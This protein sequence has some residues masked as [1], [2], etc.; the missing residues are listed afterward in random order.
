MI[1]IA[2][3][4]LALGLPAQAAPTQAVTGEE[5]LSRLRALHRSRPDDPDVARDLGLLLYRRD[6]TSGEAQR[7]L[8]VAAPRFPER[9]DVQLALLDS[10]LA[11]GDSDAVAALLA[12][13]EPELEADERFAMDTAY[14]LIGRRRFAEARTQWRRVA[15]RVQGRLQAASTETLTPAEDAELKRRVAE[16]LFV[17]GLLTARLG[18]K[19]EALRLLEQADGYGF[20]PLDSPL[21]MAAAD[22]LYEL[23]EYPLAAQAYGEVVKNAPGNAEARLRLGVSLYSS[24]DLAAARNELE[25]VLREDPHHPWAD[26]HLGAVLLEQKHTE[27]AQAHLERELTRDPRCARCMAKLAHLAYLRGD[28]S[29]CESWLARATALDPE[30]PETNLVSGMLDNRTGRY[31]QAIQHLTRVIERSPGHLKARYQLALAYQ[32]SGDAEKA[33]EQRKIYDD[34]IKAQKARTIG[35]RGTKD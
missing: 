15:K 9:R 16:V 25:R 4:A 35:V 31:D 3:V 2:V 20:P 32:R 21:M 1:P 18:E 10:Y 24:G 28:D 29:T 13:L 7:L 8:E 27:E 23:Q 14:C 6:N 26:Y 12:R 22:C 19:K 33:R 34:L 30:D 11:S 17:Q 5:A